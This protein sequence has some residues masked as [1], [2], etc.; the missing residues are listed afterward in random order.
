MRQLAS[1]PLPP[2]RQA[3]SPSLLNRRTPAYVH[4]LALFLPLPSPPQTLPTAGTLPWPFF[5][6][7]T[8][9]SEFCGTDTA[10][11]STQLTVQARRPTHQPPQKGEMVA[12]SRKP[13]RLCAGGACVLLR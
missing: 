11:A 3:V 4:S 13:P 5:S 1:L 2:T 8:D 6:L 7:G 10:P 12:L 9:S